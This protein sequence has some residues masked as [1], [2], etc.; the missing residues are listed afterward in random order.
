MHWFQQFDSKTFSPCLCLDP[1]QWKCWHSHLTP[2][3]VRQ[4]QPVG[5]IS[6][7]PFTV[8]QHVSKCLHE[9]RRSQGILPL[10]DWCHT[11][12]EMTHEENI[13]GRGSQPFLVY[14][15]MC[16]SSSLNDSSSYRIESWSWAMRF[17]VYFTV[18]GAPSNCRK[19][20]YILAETVT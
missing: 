16:R 17:W 7:S 1:E 3:A 15:L 6:H 4:S 5:G 12:T 11:V 14:N 18:E 9:S 10:T 2:Q 13:Q 8:S 19:N 20:H